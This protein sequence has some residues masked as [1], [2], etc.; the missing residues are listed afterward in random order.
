MTCQRRHALALFAL[1]VGSAFAGPAGATTAPALLPAWT[2]GT[3]DIHHIQTGRGNSTFIVG[4]DGTTILIDAGALDPADIEVANA[5]LKLAPAVP[6]ASL[7]PGQWIARYIHQTTPADHQRIDYAIITHFHTDHF[8]SVTPSSPWSATRAYRLSGITDVGDVLP[9]GV[10]IDRLQPGSGDPAPHDDLTIRNYYAFADFL[11]AK[12]GTR[13]MPLQLGTTAQIHLANTTAYPGFKVLGIK[14][15]SRIMDG[16]GGS[17]AVFDPKRATAPDGSAME[18]PFSIA[19]RLSYGSFDYYAGGDN[20]G[21]D[22]PYAPDA[23]DTESVIAPLVGPVDVM[24]LDHHGNR[25]ATNSHILENLR[26]RVMVEQV[27]TT[28]QPGGEVVH[29]IAAKGLYAGSRDIFATHLFPQTEEAIGPAMIRAFT[30]SGGHVLVRVAPGG[31]SYRVFL[32]DDL[33]V[34]PTIRA[35]FGPYQSR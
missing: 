19:L 8:G 29:R 6:N 7:R 3:L 5:P 4:P 16:A 32:L 12:R 10:L 23:V 11:K 20:T 2:P 9:I 28:D 17:R 25:D 31:A 30:A 24:A 34:K 35:V 22:E 33:A 27:Y 26:P 21:L 15:G 18:N 13:W 14:A 1:I